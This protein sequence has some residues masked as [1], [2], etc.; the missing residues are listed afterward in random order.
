MM[1]QRTYQLGVV[2]E[3]LDRARQFYESAGVG[4]FLEG[5]SRAARN[6]KVHG[7]PAPDVVVRGLIAQ[8]GPVELELLQPVAGDSIQREALDAVGE[9]ALHL[10]AYTDDLRRDVAEMAARGFPV[11]SEGEFDDGGSFAYFDTREVGGLILELYQL[12]DEA[13][14][15]TVVD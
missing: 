4:P 6:R 9:H 1:W 5:P 7:R 10:C 2:V 12:G 14:V 11:I 8:M 3:D 13:G 15:A